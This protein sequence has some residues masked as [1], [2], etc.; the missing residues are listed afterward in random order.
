MI[1]PG[2]NLFTYWSE[3]LPEW[4][5]HRSFMPGRDAMIGGRDSREVGDVK[6][7]FTPVPCGAWVE[8]VNSIVWFSMRAKWF[9]CGAIKGQ[10][11][12]VINVMIH[13]L[14]QCL[15]INVF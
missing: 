5:V 13:K 3:E 11:L 14:Q 4:D 7:L 10:D 9:H 15:H 12:L 8:N 1:N 2:L 6:K